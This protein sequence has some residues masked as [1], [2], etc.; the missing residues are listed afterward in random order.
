VCERPAR[1][2]LILRVRAIAPAP[3]PAQAAPALQPRFR[4][5]PMLE[6]LSLLFLCQLAG[7]ALVRASGLAFPGPVLGMGIMLAIVAGAGRTG[8]GLDSVADA[9]LKNLSILFVPAAV[10]VIQQVDLIAAHWL[11]LG[12]A[13]IGST[14]LTLLVTVLVF[15]GAARLIGHA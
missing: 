11:A 2:S 12:A 14:V 10:G 5:P 4:K 6:A 1:A 3:P 9:I 7:E 13:L 8:A 15:R